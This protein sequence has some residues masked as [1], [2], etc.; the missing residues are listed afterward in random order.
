MKIQRFNPFLIVFLIVGSV[1]LSGCAAPESSAPEWKPLDV[2]LL[3][4]PL[5]LEQC[6]K[7]AQQNDIQV[8]QWKARFE[9]AE[10]ELVSVKTLPNPVFSPSWDDM[11]LKDED[12]ES[13][14]SLTYGVSY[15][16]FFWWPRD[17]KIAAAK[18]ARQAEMEKIIS[19]KRQL[20]IE[21]ASA[22]FNLVADQRK[23]SLA[24]NLLKLTAESM[25]L[26]Q[27]KRELQMVSDYEVEQVQAEQLQAENDL[28]EAG[29]Q[30]RLDQLVFAFALG[31]DRPFFP[32]VEDCGDIY[33]QSIKNVIA[34]DNMP[35]SLIDDALQADPGWR[36]K[37]A[38][39]KAAQEQL[40]V[41]YRLA[42][43]LTDAS[44]SYGIKDA[45]EGT[46]SVFSF[47]FP[48]PLFDQNRGG[49]RKAQAELRTVQAEE[50]KTRRDAVAVVSQ[51]WE[52]YHSLATQWNKYTKS[53]T[54]LAQ[55]NEQAAFKL[56]T[57]GQIKYDE[58][59]LAQRD[60]R[61][62]QM[63]ASNVWRDTSTAAWELSCAIGQHDSPANTGH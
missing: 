7:L 62:S 38:A 49:I 20:T 58:L 56:F 24:E 46:G 39:V 51:S 45:P 11:G 32:T 40:Q 30:L 5:T 36:E 59:L 54:E 43:P 47:E 44:G 23:Q 33:I 12:G 50:E 41:E 22:Y 25:R 10:A 15:P 61:Q 21:V 35:S 52:Q 48:I 16:I 6:L 27:K 18:A 3:I 26:I 55:K 17:K 28:L 13:I 34:D 31:A 60:N 29:N 2:S 9:I 42:F 37:K 57:A 19:E 14:S 8:A 63:N 53:I 4:Q 1:W